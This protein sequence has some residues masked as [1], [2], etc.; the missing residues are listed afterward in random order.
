MNIKTFIDR[1][2]L[3]VMLSIVIVIIGIIGL[4]SLPLEQYPDIA[5]PT[6]KVNATYV[7]ANAET[8]MKSVVTPLEASINGVEN[9]QYMTSTAA[10]NGTCTI[11]I[12][13]KQGSDPNMAVVNV[14][15]RVAS[16]Q[17]L[18]PAE[19]T[20]S[21]VTVRKTQN[22]NLKFITLYSPD[23]RYDSKTLT[24][25][26]KINI[27]PQL[28]RIAG[29][30]E[31]NVF[32]ADYAL[33]IWLNPAKMHA[34]GL[35]PADIDNALAAQNIES[36]MG[37][38]AAESD[39]TFQYVLKYRG[40]YSDASEFRNIVI[41]ASADGGVLRLGDVA[42][43]ELGTVDYNMKSTTNGKPGA[44]ASITQTAGT[45]ANEIIKQI[46]KVEEDVRQSLPDGMVLED[47]TSVMDFLNA[48]MRNV[49]E[50]LVIALVLVVI[51][52]FVFLR[53]WRS[54][55]IPTIAILVSLI[56]TFAFMYVAGFSLN[57]LTLFALVLVIG[58]VVD[59]SI[60][61]VEA[62]QAKISQGCESVRRATAETMKGMKSALITTTIVFMAVFIP[63]SFTSGTTGVFYKE[64]GMTMAAA[65]AI[66]LFNALT[67][68]P[69]LSALILKRKTTPVEDKQNI[70]LKAYIRSILKTVKHRK[71][72]MLSLPL[73]IALLAI[74]IATTKTSLV[75]Q[76][77]MGTIDVN[78]QCRPGYSLAQTGKVMDQVEAVVKN[79]PQIK[80]HTR[81]DG[82]DAQQNQT[83]SAGFLSV[84]LK[85]WAQRSGRADDIDS[86]V[87]EI[88][89]RTAFIKEADVN[90][91]TLPTIRGYGS[92]SGFELYVQNRSGEDF[93]ALSVVTQNLTDALNKRPEIGKAHYTFNMDYPQY[94]V[95]VDAARCMMK[96]V[97]PKDVLA[98]MSAYIGGDYASNINKYTKLYRVM[99]QAEAASRLNESAL[100]NMF[101]KSTDGTMS[102][103][104]EYVVLKK[105]NGAE[106][107]TH[108]NLF[109]SIR[110]NGT[111]ATGYSSGQAI[112]AISEVAAQTLP[113]GYGYEFGGLSREESSQGNATV[114]ILALS[115]V[116]IYIILCCLYESL[117]LPFAIILVVPLGLCG[118]FLLAQAFG[119]DN[120]IYMQ[121]GLVMLIGM[122]AKTGILLTE[123]ATE[124]RKAGES[125]I[126]ATLSAATVRLRP[127]IMT[128]SVMI[129]GMLPLMLAHGAGARGNVAIGTCVVGGM[130][131]G[132]IAI[133]LLLPVLYCIFETWD[134]KIRQRK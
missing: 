28:S 57:L 58:T 128:A 10:N 64:F 55:V 11:T 78:V 38:L 85:N 29:V 53:D 131:V 14:Q 21:G 134:E 101:V 12:Y 65:V 16:A 3:S 87:N 90:C 31:V 17:G 36:P 24:N 120:S 33:R 70:W 130:V 19:V 50:T 26:M 1:P 6:V 88:Y 63:V 77:D 52:V 102:P 15:N 59:D 51:V 125:I 104:S 126:S 56:G 60:V 112:Q 115:I 99:V 45:N 118:S 122:L 39:N 127:I 82:R 13:F 114:V 30:G 41:K 116:F 121:I 46:D 124:R 117:L 40:R 113:K 47:Q 97:S 119:I 37:S 74:M 44:S 83:S 2:I 4:K 34:Y 9:M 76:E 49:T 129:I 92:A 109:P 98:T 95:E 100:R 18:L 48:S 62:V 22:S 71:L 68:C 23:G 42:R 123:Y 35:V 67:L 132:T 111:A 73:S 86:V 96:G 20:K 105:V 54:M 84:R 5:P 106:Y 110:I 91:A 66:S 94:S 133:L 27:E 103:L 72:V 79:I 75:P 25:Y 7:G 80:I 108:F 61:V 8:V 107:L 43:V 32:G 93:K 89:R 81:I 69:A